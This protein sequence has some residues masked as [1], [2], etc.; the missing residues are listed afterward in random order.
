MNDKP[1]VDWYFDVV[2]PYA[3]FQSERLADVERVASVRRV[4]V[5][6]AGLL[7]HWGQLGP[8]EIVPKRRFTFR[9]A[10]WHAARLGLPLRLPPGHPFNPLRLLRLA[11]AFDGRPDVVAAVF[12]F[13]WAEGLTADDPA[14]WR[15]LCGR[16]GVDDGDALVARPDV[17]A[18][19]LENGREAISRNVFGVPTFVTPDGE[20]FWGEDAT[21]MLL[22]HLAGAP[23]LRS[24]E[25][26]RADTLPVAKSRR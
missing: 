11:A 15:A 7:E 10:I 2:S 9:Y 12:R 19:L 6:F 24:A 21:D 3:Y 8:A 23:L 4:P 26:L 16:F 25:M 20:I 5:L 1:V 13:V 18:R 14:A 22:D 17:K